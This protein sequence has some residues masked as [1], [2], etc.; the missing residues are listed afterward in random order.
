MQVRNTA[1]L[2]TIFSMMGNF[3]QDRSP[4]RKV[5]CGI[6]VAPFKGNADAAICISTDFEMSWGWRSLDRQAAE[7]IGKTE[8][9]NVPFLLRLLD[10]YSIPITWATVGHLFLESCTRSCA[11]LAHPDMPRPRPDGSWS[12]DWY[13]HDPC[14]NV[15]E[16]PAWYAPD[17]I[18]QII[19]SKTPHEIATHSFSHI[20]FGAL[21]STPEM[22]RRELGACIE[23]MQS[24]GLSPKSLVFPRN[25]AEYSY[26]PL[27]AQAGIRAV[28]HR[29]R[30]GGIRLSHPERTAA[31]V[32]KIYESMNLR[33]ARHYDYLQKAKVFIQQAMKRH[34]A[35]SLWFHPSD[36]IEVFDTEL[37]GIL[38]YIDSERRDGR[39][40]VTTMEDVAAYYEAR[41]QFQLRTERLENVLTLCFQT[42]LDTSRYGTPE[43]SL[44][45]PAPSEP[46]SVW[47]EL[48][49][50]QRK[51]VSGRLV[52]GKRLPRLIV[53]VPVS[54]KSLQLKF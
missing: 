28:R 19:E 44:L 17:L 39:L 5:S 37:R 1:I 51:P 29:D 35:Y 3:A 7:S 15:R 42:S 25:R 38:R 12:G 33:R 41:E 47:L 11:G 46:K 10:E 30:E 8:R 22:V 54:A 16:D 27:L 52:S 2:E 20:N 14:S 48:I 53:N 34:A 50:G 18:Q 23:A 40:W 45:I 36:P 9:Q 31:G 4:G 21:Y 13:S 43:V 32:Y 24:F 6:E 49:D 26:L